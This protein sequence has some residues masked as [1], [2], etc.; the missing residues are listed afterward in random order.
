MK[1]DI[2]IIGG[3]I[4]GLATALK[5]KER[6]QDLKIALLEKEKALSQHQ[7]GNNSGVIHAGVYYKPGSLKA[8][9]CR[10]G[11]RMLVDFCDKE[12]IKYE[13][14]GKLIVATKKE[15][16]ASL[17]NLFERAKKNG[18]EKVKKI[19]GDQIKEY[20]PYA[21][22]IG[23][24]V[25][26]YTGIIDFLEVSNKYAQI[27]TERYGGEVY[28][29]HKVTDIKNYSD[30][31]EVITAN[32]NFQTKLVVN[33]AGLYSDKIAR[34]N[35]KKINVRIIPF[36]GE[37]SELS[38]EKSYLVKNLI[39]PV[40]DPNFPFLG[41]HYTRMINGGIEAGP[42]AVWAFKKEGY[43]KTD[44]SWNEFWEALAWRGFRKVMFQYWKMGMGEYY[45]SFNKS[46][47]VRSLQRLVPDIR[48]KDIVR[49]GSGVRAQACDKNGGLIDDFLI[50]EDKYQFN[51]LNAP[52]PAATASL[53]IGERLS[54]DIMK[55]FS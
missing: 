43:K 48:K 8:V 41:V 6:K 54:E 30:Y 45:R 4:V 11:Y 29:N 28:L 40:P 5:L 37:Y 39:Y 26:P 22:G 44:F 17:D 19:P 36:R 32:Q 24:L 12:S 7:T 53:S 42:N 10:K 13:L 38:K 47:L 25:V 1:Y 2:T 20:E 35:N 33:T 23:A 27:F 51:V 55:R 50:I 52:S 21:T 9:N 3:G 16:L 46:A 15:E 49:G 31:S 34:I 14:C 18:L